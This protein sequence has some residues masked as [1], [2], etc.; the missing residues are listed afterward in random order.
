MSDA[1][2]FVFLVLVVF[3]AFLGLFHL[4]DWLVGGLRT[5]RP[6]DK[7]DGSK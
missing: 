2:D 6:K 7:I 1:A 5:S 4:V 3:V